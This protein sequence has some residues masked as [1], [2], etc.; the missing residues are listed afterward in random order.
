MSKFLKRDFA[1][2]FTTTLFLVIGI[3][4]VMMY[5]HF[6]DSKVKEMHEVLGLFF[7]AAILL[8]VFVNWASMKKYF[9]KKIF[10]IASAITLIAAGFFVV[11]APSGENPKGTIIKSV[12]NAPLKDSFK[13]LNVEYDYAI[14][15]LENNGIK[16]N[17]EVSISKLAKNNKT[18]PFKIVSIIMSK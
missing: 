9:S 5:F 17:D 14:M 6:Y 2:S 4:G 16:I 18:S 7:V 13:I 12:L 11:T 15:S 1:T 8:H 3:S 10:L